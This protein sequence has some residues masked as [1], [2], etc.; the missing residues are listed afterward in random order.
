MQKNYRTIDQGVTSNGLSQ[1]AHRRPNT[2]Q[3]FRYVSVWM[4]C[5][6]FWGIRSDAVIKLSWA[7]RLTVSSAHV[8]TMYGLGSA[9]IDGTVAILG[10][11]EHQNP[12]TFR[13][14]KRRVD[15]KSRLLIGADRAPIRFSWVDCDHWRSLRLQP[16]C[17][18]S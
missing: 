13:T 7:R 8:A 9:E 11:E 10:L 6:L 17:H 1:N 15:S 2:S 14:G 4:C 18:D 5:G 16:L 12:G 3:L